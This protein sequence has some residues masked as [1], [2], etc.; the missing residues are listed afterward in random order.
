[1]FTL[2]NISTDMYIE[3]A[4]MERSHQFSNL[5]NVDKYISG[6]FKCYISHPQE[7]WISIW[8][9]RMKLIGIL[10][11]IELQHNYN[12][13]IAFTVTPIRNYTIKIHNRNQ[14]ISKHALSI[15]ISRL[16]WRTSGS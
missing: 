7:P 6:S 8:T 1:M 10:A 13:Q 3:T 2:T 15:L 14:V 16:T 5:P 9:E 4:L 11:T 12:G